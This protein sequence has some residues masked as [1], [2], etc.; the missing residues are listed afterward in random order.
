MIQPKIRPT[1][2]P[3]TVSFPED[4]LATLDEYCRFLGSATD[5]THVITEAVRQVISRDKRFRRATH[6]A[7]TESRE[8]SARTALKA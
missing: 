8:T 3:V 7:A 2:K 6:S 5:R 1:L 4:E